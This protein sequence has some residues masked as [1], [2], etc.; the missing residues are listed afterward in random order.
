MRVAPALLL[1][2]AACG[3]SSPPDAR[4]DGVILEVDGL[5][6]TRA[7]VARFDAYV[8]SIDRRVGRNTRTMGILERHLIPLKLAERAFPEERRTQRERCEALAR[9]VGNGGYPELALKGAAVGKEI[10]VTPSELPM[11]I[12]AWMFEDE[13]LG[14]VSPVLETPQGFCLAASYDIRRAATRPQDVAEGFLATFYTHDATEFGA[15]LKQAEAAIA[16]HVTYVDPD[17]RD[18]IPPWLFSR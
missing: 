18:A 9:V 15:W 14:R 3:E 16:G 11:A 8:D 6:F 4:S 1:V 5:R 2:L 7:E 17:Y 10:V 12:A 13:H